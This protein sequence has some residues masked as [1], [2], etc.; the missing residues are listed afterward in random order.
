MTTQTQ[1]AK[2][3]DARK[4]FFTHRA[5]AVYPLRLRPTTD[6]HIVFLNYWLLKSGIKDIGINIRVYDDHG[7]IFA[8]QSFEGLSLHNEFSVRD[9]ILRPNGVNL[10]FDGMVEVE[11]VSISNL[12]FPFPAI[13]GIYEADG[14]FSAVHA[15]GRI[16]NA[17][18][19]KKAVRSQETNWNCCFE[20]S[21]NGQY[22]STVPFFHYFV[23][24][25]PPASDETIEVS[26]RNSWV[27]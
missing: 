19:P 13:V 2:A 26:L 22:Y 4:S 16:K 3:F 7:K 6:L 12:A 21:T 18:E 23:G 27:R 15:A 5:S 20:R 24:A 25:M 14:R 11:V 10:P 9:N 8:R 17:D 1:L